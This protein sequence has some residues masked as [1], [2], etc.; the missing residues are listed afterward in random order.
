MHFLRES[1]RKRV[2]GLDLESAARL[3]TKTDHDAEKGGLYPA[4]RAFRAYY[5]ADELII[6]NGVIRGWRYGDATE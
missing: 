6:S 4:I 2:V 1:E 3:V 5:K